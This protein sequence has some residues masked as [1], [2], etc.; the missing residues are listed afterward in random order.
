MSDNSILDN[1]VYIER[2]L[3]NKSSKSFILNG[4]LAR[5]KKNDLKKV[6]SLAKEDLDLIIQNNKEDI[7]EIEDISSHL[8][9]KIKLSVR[10]GNI[11]NYYEKLETFIEGNKIKFKNNDFYISD[12]DYRESEEKFNMQIQDYKSN[13]LLISFLRKIADNEKPSGNRL[14]LFFYK[15]NVGIDLN[16]EYSL[17]NLHL[18]NIH[19]NFIKSIQESDTDEKKQLFVNELINFLEKNG[20]SY[21]KLVEGWNYLIDSYNKSYSLFLSGFSFEKIKTSS[22]EY[23]QKLTDRIYESISKASNYIFGIP[24]GY[25]LLINNL[26]FTGELIFKNFSI[27][28]LGIIFFI[29][30]AQILFKNIKESILAIERDIDDFKLKIENYTELDD[31]K[32]KL[33]RLKNQDIVK[34]KRKIKIVKVLSI[35]IFTIIVFMY[36]F[37]FI[38]TSIFLI[39]F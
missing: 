6:E 39:H 12:I 16:I 37:I 11:Q 7:I 15:T 38:D 5:L 27:L 9:R 18:V 22:N 3:I 33:D 25:I 29:L 10:T 21:I 28:I 24:I 19:E 13:I 23:F 30:I 8:N 31:I 34:Q 26:D 2:R 35:C 20:K 32:K 17:S 1:I 14:N 4:E 36:I